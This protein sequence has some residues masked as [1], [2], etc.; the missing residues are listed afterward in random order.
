MSQLIIIFAAYFIYVSALY[1]AAYIFW[2]HDRKFFLRDTIF[3]LGTALASWIIAH[4]L[5]DL[6]AH[7]RPDLVFALITPD[8]LYSFPSGHASFMFAL[9][10]AMNYFNFRAGLIIVI[11]ALLT[12]M[13]RV[14]AGV[15]FWYDI[16]GGAILGY[17]VS[18][19][20]IMI[21]KRLTKSR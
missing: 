5:K 9:G 3:L 10:F 13:A 1:A 19:V 4:Y 14:L 11:L 16:V 17:L 6:I 15:H 2:K 18:L 21:F 20:A 7:P 12:G 8:S